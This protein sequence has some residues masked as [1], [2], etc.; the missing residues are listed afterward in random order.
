[1]K[2]LIAIFA[3]QFRTKEIWKRVWELNRFKKFENFKEYKGRV[4]RVLTKEDV[5]SIIMTMIIGIALIA[6][7]SI[8]FKG[9]NLSLA[10]I[11]SIVLFRVIQTFAES[12]KS[13]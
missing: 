4:S 9:R 3:E 2:S 11:S 8:F 1:M 12:I 13:K 7:L 10:I 6:V 5:P